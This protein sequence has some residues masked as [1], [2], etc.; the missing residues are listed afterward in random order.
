VSVTI[1]RGEAVGY[2]GP[3]GA[4]KSTTIMILTGIPVPG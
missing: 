3:N 4:G 1:E 2:V